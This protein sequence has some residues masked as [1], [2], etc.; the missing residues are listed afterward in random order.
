MPHRA[1]QARPTN[2]RPEGCP[3]VEADMGQLRQL[4]LNLI[5]N[6]F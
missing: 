4:L 2:Y 5:L 6:W 3:G 1:W